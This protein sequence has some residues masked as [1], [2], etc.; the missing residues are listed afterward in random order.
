MTRWRAP[1]AW[2][3]IVSLVAFIVYRNSHPNKAPDEN[4]I[5]IDDIRIQVL[6]EELIGIKSLGALAGQ[7]QTAKLIENQQRLISD[8][9]ST[10]RTTSDRLHIAMIAGEVLGKD[11]ALSRLSAIEHSSDSPPSPE[12]LSDIALLRK[13]Y[14]SNAAALDSSSRNQ[15]LQRH[16]YFARVALSYGVSAGAE[17]RKSIEAGGIRATI[18]VGVIGLAILLMLL[19]GFGFFIAAFVLWR[20]GR[21]RRA[22]RPDP[23]AGTVY[24][25]GFAIYLVLFILGFGLIRRYFHL[26]NLQW[27]WFALLIIPVVLFWFFRNGAGSEEQ[28]YALG[29]H[30]G[31][32]VLRE[33]G[34][35]VAGYLA[36]L[37]VV[38][39]GFLV[40][41]L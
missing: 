24:L 27:E 17:P 4:E 18:M 28:R 38:M 30:A 8:L 12:Q 9:E 41:Y 15:L 25:E 31:K 33:I 32:G 39:V 14:S 13:I 2:L 16:D 7:L 40:T 35:G 19:S 23:A 11:Q 21:L 6:G 36:G 1:L 10:A 22:Y 5:T 37:V 29:W 26:E 34:A 20:K 3:V